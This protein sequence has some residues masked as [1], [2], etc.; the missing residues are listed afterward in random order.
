MVIQVLEDA[1]CKVIDAHFLYLGEGD[2]DFAVGAHLLNESG[3]TV[4]DVHILIGLVLVNLSPM[5]IVD[6]NSVA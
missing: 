6:D 1:V 5:G 4:T 3:E 2:I